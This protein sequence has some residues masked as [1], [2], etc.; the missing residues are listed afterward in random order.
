VRVVN[1]LIRESRSGRAAHAA[2]RIKLLAAVVALVAALVL[3][4]WTTGVDFLKRVAPGMVVMNPMT[5]VAFLL[6]AAS[7]WSGRP[8]AARGSRESRRWFSRVC[9]LLA[10]AIG[11]ARLTP[12]A[13]GWDFGVDQWLFASEFAR[14]PLLPKRMVPNTALNFLLIGSALFLL[15]V[16]HR[17]AG[18]AASAL[19]LIAG[20]NALVAVLAYGYRIWSFYEFGSFIGMGLHT[21]LCFFGLAYGVLASQARRGFL[22]AL[23][24][25]TAAGV[26]SRRLLPSAIL[27]PALLGWWV[28]EGH[29]VGLYS[30]ELGI[31][32]YAVASMLLFGALVC[33]SA[34]TILRL[35]RARTQ[36]KRRLRREH[37]LL[38][39]RVADRT[40]ELSRAHAALEKTHGELEERVVERTLELQAALRTNQ[41]IMNNSLDVICTM[42]AQGRFTAVS[43]ASQEL[44]GYTPAEM[45]GR[46]R[47]EFVH[48][49]DRAKTLETAR[50]AIAGEMIADFD[51]RYLHRDGSVVPVTWSA[52]WSEADQSMFCVG[53]DSTERK[54][55]EHALEQAR[56]AA[57]R[58][59]R[60]KS[61]FLSRMS[62]ELRTPMN[63][64]LGF[65]Q[66][67]ELEEGMSKE[68][69][70]SVA[71]ILKGGRH[72]L[73]LINEVLDISRIEAGRMTLS[74]EAVALHGVLDES[75]RL[76]ETLAD[77][78]NVRLVVTPFEG[79]LHVLAD[80][81]RLKQV[82]LNLLANAIKYNRP[83]GSVTVGCAP[84]GSAGGA[85]AVRIAVR[86]TGPGI[87][88]THLTRLFTP[89]ERIGADESSV[90]GTGLGLVLAKRMVDLMGGTLGVESVV[91]EGSTF[92]IELL[93]AEPPAEEEEPVREAAA[94]LAATLP[95][96]PRVIIYIEDNL[97]NLR[98][99]ERVLTR[100]PAIRLIPAL[101][102]R[103]GL[104]LVREHRPD[105]VLLD[106]NLPDIS[107]REVLARMRADPAISTVPVLVISA[108]ATP[109]QSERLRAEGALGYLTKPL[110]VRK[111]L[112]VVDA[113]LER[114]GAAPAREVK[115]SNPGEAEGPLR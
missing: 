106:L 98:L 99:I 90:E 73:G 2:R 30:P 65:A 63:A 103:R 89:F 111:F 53:R 114:R 36:A 1:E 20:G 78:F 93:R 5:A 69:R 57:D 66:V 100:R 115:Q 40:A 48:P 84:A 41:Q 32:L 72:L 39:Q 101:D 81:Q 54:R 71:Q 75:V 4:G 88:P 112:E 47:I 59:N 74:R 102:G 38:E 33:G 29:R 16:R 68:Q 82:L 104:E 87:S 95:A 17:R 46:Y 83:G 31:A 110:D 52:F 77:D 105:L 43:S 3:A 35:D 42:D 27:M 28:L 11:A 7:L 45:L 19:A 10:G 61:E 34:L 24:G 60:G 79:G 91:G 12:L 25:S 108:D 64:I 22:A 67:L 80:R 62:H 23:V 18:A 9:A 44:W 92:W 96:E 51:N 37:A 70:E 50:R 86:D 76:L 109:G 55:I 58:A 113:A 49:H 13:F 21:A 85:P 6:A 97:P 94:S 8:S 14:E 107:G 15:Q 26:L 56:E